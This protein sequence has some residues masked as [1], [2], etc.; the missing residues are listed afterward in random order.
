M[1]ELKRSFAKYVDTSMPLDVEKVIIRMTSYL[2]MKLMGC[3][4]KSM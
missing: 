1:A 3:I 2:D 4:I